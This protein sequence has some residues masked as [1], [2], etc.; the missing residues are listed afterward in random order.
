MVFSLFIHYTGRIFEVRSTPLMALKKPDFEL[1]KMMVQQLRDYA[2]FLLDPEGRIMSW[3]AGAQLLK[4][5]DAEEIIGKHFSVF[6]PQEA[7]DREWPRR[8]LELAMLEGRF[9]D[10]GWRLRKD[11]SRFWANVIITCLR[12]DKGNLLGFSKITRDLTVRRQQE[13]KLRLSEERFRLLVESV[14]DYA[15]YMLDRDGLVVSW[16]TG[17]QRIKGYSSAV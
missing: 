16:N 3:N 1:F 2:I 9:E 8:E 13:E 7:K 10:E 14:A 4:G 12:D 5:Y 6:Y 15:I 17:A 11:G